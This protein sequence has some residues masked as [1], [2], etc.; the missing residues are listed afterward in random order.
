MGLQGQLEVSTIFV[1]HIPAQVDQEWLKRTLCR[2]EN[3]V[4]LFIPKKRRM[5]AIDFNGVRCL[6]NKL[7][8][9]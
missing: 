1:H 5:K 2:C 3:V 9:S 4:K 8:V 6:K 7:A